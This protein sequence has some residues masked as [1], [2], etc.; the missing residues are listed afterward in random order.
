MFMNLVCDKILAISQSNFIQYIPF[1]VILKAKPRFDGQVTSLNKNSCC[2]LLFTTC[3]ISELIN[4]SFPPSQGSKKNLIKTKSTSQNQQNLEQRMQAFNMLASLLA[5]K[6]VLDN[7][8][9]I[10]SLQITFTQFEKV[11]SF[12]S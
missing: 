4:R 3:F 7:T 11:M 12:Q 1:Y 6:D 2:E 5:Q 10:K 9:F 8:I